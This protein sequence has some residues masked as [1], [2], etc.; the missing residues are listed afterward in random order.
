[1][2]INLM[3]IRRRNIAWLGVLAALIGIVFI[4]GAASAEVMTML[5]GVFAVAF[6]AS[7]LEF[8]P[9]RW[10]ETMASS[11][12]TRMR[13]S[14]EAREAA[15]RARR[16]V[17]GFAGS[18]LTLL[19][20]GLIS[21]QSNPDGVVMRKNRSVSGDDD[22]VRPFV[23]LHVPANEA[24]RQTHVRFEII[25]QNGDQRY[26]HEMKTFLRDGE[27]NILADH[28]LPLMNNPHIGRVGGEWDLRV[29]VDSTWIG[30]LTFTVTPSLY[31]R[32]FN[33]QDAAA[34]LQDQ[35]AAAA[36]SKPL[37]FEDLLR[38]QDNE[39]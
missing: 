38:S 18:D 39:G 28:H 23:T 20:I 13:M 25:D 31:Q 9:A 22:G 3:R 6:I 15:D 8:Q 36:S 37:S 34:R 33:D 30:M 24:D 1:V 35:P 32:Q 27:M 10:R 19:D 11:P 14:A 12:L 16:R 4:S 2:E 7:M 17:G 5:V 29:S 21:S 26:V